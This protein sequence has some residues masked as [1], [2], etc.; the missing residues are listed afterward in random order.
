MKASDFDY[1]LPEEQIAYHPV[2]Q[3]QNSKLL[4]LDKNGGKISHR[5][6]YELPD[7]LNPGDLLVL[8]NTKVI[9]ARLYGKR[10][11]GKEI[12]ILLVKKIDATKWE[13]LVKNP[14]DNLEVIFNEGVSGKLHLS[15]EGDWV[16]Q[17]DENARKYLDLYGKMPLP[18]YIKREPCDADKISYQ[19][20]YAKNEGAIAAPTA[21]L[22]F[23]RELLDKIKSKGVEIEYVTLHVG[24]GTFKPVKVENIKDH[25]M[26]EEYISVPVSAASAVNK[27][28]AEG[29][30]VIAVGTTVVRTLESSV[31]EDGEVVSR[32]GQTDLFILPGFK[33][34]AVDALIT[35]FHLP[36]S[37]L[38]MLVSAFSRREYIFRAY[39]EAREHNYRFLSYG[40]AMFI[41]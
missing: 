33:F 16:I 32:S 26:H 18:P 4:L 38:L 1:Y 20:V 28:K 5:N 24:I 36:C 23:T 41:N 19:T 29:R 15:E 13:C 35:N 7:F 6:F 8:N 14:K 39:D 25:K 3:R 31:N 2:P 17:F 30:R 22:H 37:T 40:D 21:G 11:S 12:E 34:K 9:P 10:A 27:A